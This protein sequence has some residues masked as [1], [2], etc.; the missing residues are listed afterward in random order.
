[1][2]NSFNHLR[3]YFF[4]FFIFYLIYSFLDIYFI[5][6]FLAAFIL[7]IIKKEVREKFYSLIDTV[8]KKTFCLLNYKRTNNFLKNVEFKTSG[9]IFS[10]LG[11]L[12]SILYLVLLVLG[13]ISD[14]EGWLLIIISPPSVIILLV[15]LI[16]SV[17]GLFLAI[18]K[19]QKDM[20]FSATVKLI[21]FFSLF[22][23]FVI[24]IYFISYFLMKYT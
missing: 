23:Y 6:F 17:V 3:V 14:S 9:I 2:K 13:V 19:R 16:F 1:M 11:F 12:I 8:I 4:L 18:K 21:L 20:S 10:F 22:P 5:I 24:S 15:M 7:V